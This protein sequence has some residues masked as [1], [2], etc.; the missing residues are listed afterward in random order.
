MISWFKVR[1]TVLN[2]QL[3]AVHPLTFQCTKK[4]ES[5]TWWG[6]ETVHLPVSGV[7]L[8]CSSS[9]FT[10]RPYPVTQKVFP[11]KH[12]IQNVMKVQ[13]QKPLCFTELL[14][15]SG[16]VGSLLLVFFCLIC[17]QDLYQSIT[18]SHWHPE[19][20][21]ECM[22]IIPQLLDKE[23]EQLR[24]GWSQYFLFLLLFLRRE[25]TTKSSYLLQ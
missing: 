17:L 1:R 14:P 3:P 19:V 9:R 13:I 16:S 20:N 21:S 11:R 5:W 23:V 15:D 18:G 24:I 22:E 4:V 12:L 7:R 10:M 2:V 8:C 25:R 6:R